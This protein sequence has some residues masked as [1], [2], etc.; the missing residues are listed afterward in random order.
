MTEFDKA[1]QVFVRLL[2]GAYFRYCDDILLIVPSKDGQQTYNFVESEIK[3]LDLSIQTKK[4]E[5]RNFSTVD[6]LLLADKPLQYLGFLY[7]GQRI[8]LRSSALARFSDR[9]K[10]GVRLAKL[11]MKK[12]NDLRADRG[13]ATKPLFK[14]KIYQRYSLLGRRNF[15]SYGFRAAEI[16]NANAIRKQLKPL[17]RKLQLEMA[18]P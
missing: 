1:V 17:W 3:K 18:K 5:R 15:V 9:M 13:H 2:G 14:K 8:L 4:T 10:R 6:G 11:T 16:M 12:R 7:D